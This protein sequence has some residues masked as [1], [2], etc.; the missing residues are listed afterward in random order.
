MV[1]ITLGL[2]N[3]AIALRRASE[4]GETLAHKLNEKQLPQSTRNRVA[5]A[6][7]AVAMDHQQAVVVLLERHPPF[8]SSAFSLVRPVYES[9]VRGLWL[10]HCA[11]DE[12]VDSFSQGD[13]PPDMASL[14]AEVERVGDFEGKQ[15]SGIYKRSWSAL[16]SYTHTGALQVQRWN[17]AD[18]IEPMY[19]AS[20]VSEVISFTS[21]IALL[22]AVSVAALARNEPLAQDLLNIA[23]SHAAT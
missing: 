17:T 9:Y 11:T 12:Q 19:P 8:Y 18:A 1:Y 2:M 20:E 13:K 7:F 21:A 5:G 23:K 16:S 4:L 3:T 15:L 6:C 22:S 10:S 14:V